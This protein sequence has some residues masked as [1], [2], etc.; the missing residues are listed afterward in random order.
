MHIQLQRSFITTVFVT[1]CIASIAAGDGPS[2]VAKS[3]I[4]PA[5]FDRPAPRA[6][7][8]RV[9]FGQLEA[10]VGDKVEQ[11]FALEL[12]L[13]T[14]VRQANQLI[15]KNNTTVRNDQR[16]IVETTAVDA[17]RTMAVKVQYL[18]ATKQ[19]TVGGGADP[20]T[21]R[22]PSSLPQPVQGKSYLCQR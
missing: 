17:G 5:T 1:M 6:D 9:A 22:E 7:G 13:T 21:A 15:E 2:P 19:I 3:A 12:H 4:K 8:Q 16:R 14:A 20:A 10:R 18:E 11:E